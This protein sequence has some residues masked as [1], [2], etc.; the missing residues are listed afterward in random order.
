MSRKVGIDTCRESFLSEGYLLMDSVY[1]DS[2]TKMLCECPIGHRYKTTWFNWHVNKSRCPICNSGVKLT[3]R[4]IE[5]VMAVEGYKLLSKYINSKT[6]ISLLCDKN[7]ACNM[8]YGMWRSGVR[9]KTCS[10]ENRRSGILNTIRNEFDKEGYTLL[11]TKYINTESKLKFI[12]NN[13][14]VSDISWHSWKDNHRC[15][16]CAKVNKLDIE[17]VSTYILSTGYLLISKSY[18]NCRTKLHLMCPNGHDYY[19]SW[20]HFKNKGSRCPLCNPYSSIP[21]FEIIELINKYYEYKIIHNDRRLIYPYELDI[22]IPDKKIA[23]EYCGLYWHSEKMGHDKNY[24]LNKLS[25]CEKI[26]YRLITV[27]EDEW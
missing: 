17:T 22:V 13:E 11:S 21:E 1:K 7:H 23:I 25:M 15:R 5:N 18:V 16:I 8:T 14:H 9:C 2:K 27:F 20:D 4:Y 19:V 6:P 3:S 26:G 12:C 10:D 24:H